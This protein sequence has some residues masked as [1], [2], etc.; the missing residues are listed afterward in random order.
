MAFLKKTASGPVLPLA[1]KEALSLI[2]STGEET[3]LPSVTEGRTVSIFKVI[4]YTIF[5]AKDNLPQ[6]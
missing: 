6:M 5:S 3:Y 1:W 4:S 2:N